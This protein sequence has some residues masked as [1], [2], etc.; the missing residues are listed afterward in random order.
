MGQAA[1]ES[2]MGTACETAGQL[3]IRE[4]EV[5]SG[6]RQRGAVPSTLGIWA[7]QHGLELHGLLQHRPALHVADLPRTWRKCGYNCGPSSGSPAELPSQAGLNPTVH[8][9]F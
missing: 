6:A 2:V 3:S 7:Q 4:P 5:P 8:I 1:A 9:K